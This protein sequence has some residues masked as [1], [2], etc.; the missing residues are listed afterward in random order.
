MS[1]A[2]DT[3]T[4]A[5]QVNSTSLTYSHTCTGSDRILFVTIQGQTN[6]DNVT[7]VTYAG[8][9]MTLID[10]DLYPTNGRWSYL[11]YLIAP[12]TGA[13]NIVIS[14]SVTT[15]LG[16]AAASYTGV[17]QTSPID[18]STKNTTS[19]ASSLTTTLTTTTDNCWTVMGNANGIGNSTGG[20]SG[21]TLRETD[22]SGYALFDS[23]AAITPAGSTSLIS[24]YSGS[25]PMVQIMAAFKPV[26]S[27]PTLNSNFFQF[28]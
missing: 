17:D 5:A 10:K 11:Y 9:S 23:N 8:V 20:G 25:G 22:G 28:M 26:A 4:K 3:S 12:T 24:Q 13:N 18:A 19:S 7:G 15:F 21:T 16:S 1:I 6:S 14:A 2:F 27:A